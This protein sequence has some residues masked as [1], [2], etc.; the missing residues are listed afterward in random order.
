MSWGL[1]AS[2]N[3]LR[4]LLGRREHDAFLSAVSSAFEAKPAAESDLLRALGGEGLALLLR[5][6]DAASDES[7]VGYLELLQAGRIDVAPGDLRLVTQSL[8]PRLADGLSPDK[9]AEIHDALSKL[10]EAEKTQGTRP[11]PRALMTPPTPP[12]QLRR[13]VQ[14]IDFKLG[15]FPSSDAFGLKQSVFKSAQERTFFAA[16]RLRYPGLFALPNYGLN[17]LFDWDRLR[18]LVDLETWNYARQCVLD[19]VL[20]IP[21]EGDPV[22]AFELDSSWHDSPESVVRDEMKDDLLQLLQIPLV[23]LRVED[24]TSMG[25]DEWYALLTDQV[26]DQISCGERIAARHVDVAIVPVAP[27]R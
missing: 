27:A 15:A 10:A 11:A 21:D 16:L 1:P 8:L 22:A 9:L 13:V 26:L 4:S 5:S 14:S 2:F 18:E 24:S 20:I 6:L 12:L 19:A 3:H 25:V 7:C 17:Q 23:R